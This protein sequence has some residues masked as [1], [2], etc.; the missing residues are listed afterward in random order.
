MRAAFSLD[1]LVKERA[2]TKSSK[3]VKKPPVRPIVMSRPRKFIPRKVNDVTPEWLT[4][5]LTDS[6]VLK[7]ATI[8]S[9]DINIIG[10]DKGFMGQVARIKL[11]Y[12]TPEKTSPAS[13]IVK[14]PSPERGRRLLGDLLLHNEAENRLYGEFLPD[15]PLRTPRC[16]FLDMDP[17]PSERTVKLF[18]YLVKRLPIIP[19]FPFLV[20]IVLFALIKNR[21]Y[22]LILEDLEKYDQ[23]DQ[24]E[25][26][27]FEEAKIVL[28]NLARS[29]AVF[30]ESPRIKTHWLMPGFEFNKKN[31]LIFNK[32]LARFQERYG[33]SVSDKG[34]MVIKWLTDNNSDLDKLAM[35]RPYTLVHGDFRLDNLFFD[36]ENNNIVAVD[37]QAAHYGP[38]VFDAAYFCLS[39]GRKGFTPEQIKELAATYHQSLVNGGVRDYT[40]DE[41]LKDYQLAQLLALRMTLI[42][43]GSPDLDENPDLV[44]LFQS[45][46]D[47]LMPQLDGFDLDITR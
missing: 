9:F 6:G 26:C 35:T 27:T 45:W 44:I 5:V 25:G 18:T 4:S 41:C 38:G 42:L 19:L 32:S 21:R 7:Q 3:R 29:Q 10:E 8:K 15:L 33:D 23:I 36:R 24:R 22:V 46:I 2:G 14:L 20:L 16:Y 39:A 43:A 37:W 30:W 13:V 28:A 34:Q 40:F 1:S 31:N 47:R 11:N 17:G 12:D